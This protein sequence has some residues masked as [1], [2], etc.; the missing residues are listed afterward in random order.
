MYDKELI[1]KVLSRDYN[2]KLLSAFFDYDLNNGELSKDYGMRVLSGVVHRHQ[3]SGEFYRPTHFH[4]VLACSLDKD[5]DKF[6]ELEQN[7]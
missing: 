2:V 7:I 1:E 3:K 4:Y 5:S 6:K